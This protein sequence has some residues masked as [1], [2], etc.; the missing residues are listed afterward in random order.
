ML[1]VGFSAPPV[2]HKIFFDSIEHNGPY[3][4]FQVHEPF[5]IYHFSAVEPGKIRASEAHKLHDECLLLAIV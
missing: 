3:T 5:M 2:V 4:S 1:H